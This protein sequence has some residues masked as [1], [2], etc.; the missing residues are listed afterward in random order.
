MRMDGSSA[1]S[2]LL[3]ASACASVTS[4]SVTPS[5]SASAQPRAA[6][7]PIEFFRSKN[8]DRPYEELAGLHAQFGMSPGEVQEAMRVKACEVGADAVIITR[9]YDPGSLHV[10]AIMTGTAVKY[11]AAA[12]V[13]PTTTAR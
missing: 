12:E 7:C 4:V 8:P 1:L 10:A 2:L 6:D 11:R 3:L 9:D 5:G 13:Q